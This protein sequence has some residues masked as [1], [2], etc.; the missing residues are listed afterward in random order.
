M[1]ELGNL[2]G[3]FQKIKIMK[4]FLMQE[5][6]VFKKEEVSKKSC[7]PIKACV[8]E[9]KNLEKNKFIEKRD[10]SEPGRV[11]KSGKRGKDIKVSGYTLNQNYPYV[12][13]LQSLFCGKTSLNQTEISKK[14]KKVGRLKLII[15]SGVFIQNPDSRI[16]MLVVADGLSPSKLKRAMIELE[17]EVGREIK[18]SAFDT[19]DFK[20]RLGLCDKLIRDVLDYP[21]EVVVDKLGIN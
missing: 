1:E 11:L 9:I 5:G 20:Y 13:P 16:D 15:T 17:S 2:F 3:N 8:K 4:L 12:V 10:F 19:L 21:H 7:V 18:Y 6:I 14:F